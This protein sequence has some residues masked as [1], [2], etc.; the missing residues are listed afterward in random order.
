MCSD[1]A[2]VGS[3][4]VMQVRCSSDRLLEASPVDAFETGA[5]YDFVIVDEAH[6]VYSHAQCV[7]SVSRHV[8]GDTRLL[9]LSDL[10]QCGKSESQI[11]PR[12]RGAHS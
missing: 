3:M 11:F 12:T 5:E 1:D 4:Q 7:A 10:S 8:N 6:T 9:L 2:D